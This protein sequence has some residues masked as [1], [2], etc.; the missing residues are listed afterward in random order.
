MRILILRTLRNKSGGRNNFKNGSRCCV[1]SSKK[2]FTVELGFYTDDYIQIFLY[3][4]Y[5]FGLGKSI[6]YLKKSNFKLYFQY[7]FD[8][9]SFL[10][11]L[12]LASF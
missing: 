5:L 9:C 6:L 10:E 3:F 4:K 7:R 2:V 12:F 8:S 11:P 1:K